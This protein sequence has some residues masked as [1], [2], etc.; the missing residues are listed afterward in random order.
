MRAEEA[1]KLADEYNAG[2]PERRR[3][4]VNEQ[5]DILIN[6]IK[7]LASIGQVSETYN[8]NSLYKETLK[9]LLELG[10]KIDSTYTP[11][12]TRITWGKR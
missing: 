2:E 8:S 9:R 12:L 3:A 5:V 7:K 4:R 6:D 10:Y 1:A 11:T